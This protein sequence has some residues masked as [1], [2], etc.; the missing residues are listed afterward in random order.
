MRWVHNISYHHSMFIRIL[1]VYT[2]FFFWHYVKVIS[3][4]QVSNKSDRFSCQIQTI[5]YVLT[6]IDKFYFFGLYILQGQS[7]IIYCSFINF[8]AGTYY[9]LR[10][11]FT[12]RENK[13]VIGAD[14]LQFTVLILHET[15][16]KSNKLR[17][18]ILVDSSI[19]I[20]TVYIWV[21]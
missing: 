1:C 21:I 3:Y 2:K 7:P 15:F 18:Q 16:W 13:Y 10:C 19:L 12:W 17:K 11:Q 6:I 14:K 5:N 8:L 20:K 4:K 9:F